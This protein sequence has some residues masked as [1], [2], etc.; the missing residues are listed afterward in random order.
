ML[1]VAEIKRHQNLRVDSERHKCRFA[2]SNDTHAKMHPRQRSARESPSRRCNERFIVGQTT[3]DQRQ[4]ANS[5]RMNQPKTPNSSRT[6]QSFF[7]RIRIRSL[8][9]RS[10]PVF[11]LT[12]WLIGPLALRA[13]NDAQLEPTP[14]NDAATAEAVTTDEGPPEP[15][16]P[17][18]QQ[19]KA[20]EAAAARKP[21]TVD[22]FA[23]NEFIELYKRG[24]A[25]SRKQLAGYLDASKLAGA[26]QAKVGELAYKLAEFIDRRKLVNAELLALMETGEPQAEHCLLRG[27]PLV[28]ADALATSQPTTTSAPA[29]PKPP[30]EICLIRF[31]KQ[32]DGLWRFGPD[33]VVRIPLLVVEA[34]PK[35]PTGTDTTAS[36]DGTK[37]VVT[38]P[39]PAGDKP[40]VVPERPPVPKEFATVQA[41]MRT[42]FRTFDPKLADKF[43]PADCLN[44]ADRALTPQDAW[45]KSLA[46]GVKFVLDRSIFVQIASLPDNPDIP[47]P[48][49]YTSVANKEGEEAGAI[50]FERMPDGRWLISDGTLDQLKDMIRAVFDEPPK[51]PTAQ[52]LSLFTMPEIY[53]LVYVPDWATQLWWFLEL[54]QWIGVLAIIVFGVLADR[55]ARI[56]LRGVSRMLFN[57]LSKHTSIELR[58][59][60][61]RPIGIVLMGYVWLSLFPLLWTP[62]WFGT[63]LTTTSYLVMVLAA[64]WSTYRIIDIISSIASV[65]LDRRTSTFDDL[66]V[67]FLRKFLKIVVTIIGIVY[68][69]GRIYPDDV[70]ALLGGLG[71]GGLAFALAA[72]DTIKNVFGSITVMLDRPFEIGD[73]IKLEGVEGMVE[74]VGF[75]ST[76]VRTFSN[77]LISV[78]NGKLIEA[79]VD[80]FGRRQY[81]RLSCKLNVTYS[82]TPEQLEAFC[83]GI[84]ELIRR[85]PYTRKDLYHVYFNE[86]GAHSL[87][88][89][90]YMFFEAPD[91]ATELRERHRLLTDILRLSKRIGVDFAF[92]TQTLHLHNADEAPPV[93]PHI[94]PR[95]ANLAA[96]IIGRSEA[97]AIAKITVPPPDSIQPVA[98]ATDPQPVDED[99]I[100]Q[101]LGIVDEPPPEKKKGG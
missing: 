66:L 44:L 56:L 4:D 79:V 67:P 29:E 78:P 68:F 63:L 5:F 14:A 41:T 95:A 1:P 45:A 99:Y 51:V 24:D 36:T 15:A 89:L 86:F 91:W 50:R 33:T 25:E 73:W 27:A 22:R 11:L 61:F 97:A 2:T 90:V 52:E 53:I 13:Q 34:S 35:P 58:Q 60:S 76:R 84:R 62:A 20:A 81:R 21:Q 10:L 19:V 47:S 40:A 37:P 48:Y 57:R 30:E 18:T 39:P 85:H 7:A 6:H 54:W 69:F 49:F 32:A 94:P 43:T 70:D 93:D 74:S 87:D 46:R 83:E 38:Q 8:I 80:N 64:I 92:P 55:L 77:S 9:A 17:T 16:Q 96:D 101:R 72:Q 42:F 88:I 82:T 31:M 59:T 65:V 28:Q 98:I 71:L 23:L 26:D 100:K 12:A 3:D 75:R